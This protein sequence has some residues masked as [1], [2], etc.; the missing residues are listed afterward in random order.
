MKGIGFFDI[1]RSEG[2]FK[3]KAV[4]LV[5]HVAGWLIA[6][7]LPCR[8]R[9]VGSLTQGAVRFLIIRPGGMGDAVFLLPIIR[10]LKRMGHS[11]DVLCE[12]RNAQ[13]FTSQ[14]ELCGRVFCYDV[15]AEFRDV[16]RHE[17]DVVVDTE[18]WHHLSAI[19]AYFIRSSLTVGFDTRFSRAKLFDV[20]VTHDLAEYEL[21]CFTR[22][23]EAFGISSVP[24]LKGSYQAPI[25][26]ISWAKEAVK[27]AYVAFALGGSISLR[28][29]TLAQ[30][31]SICRQALSKG[32]GVV[33]VGGDDV[34]SYAHEVVGSIKD[35]RVINFVGQ[36]TLAKSA[37][38][39]A[40]AKRFIGHDSGLLHIAGA[41]GIPSIAIFGPGN[42][43]K[44]SPKGVQ[45]VV[46]H[47]GLP[48]SPCTRFGYTVVTCSGAYV[49]M[50]DILKGVNEKDL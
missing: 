2:T 6:C 44:W 5:D 45:D 8:R 50:Q 16:F 1:F 20:K 27:G 36:T 13:I 41:L 32:Y 18:Q 40:G 47:T 23:F 17:Y 31:Q 24:Q 29:F 30:V 33:L 19:V 12:R 10:E 35:E 21:K 14:Q 26:D 25:A 43:E 11:V 22:L 4:K 38:L 28:R 37:A 34:A 7:C 39:I 15:L 48:C 3:L 42:K 9:G 46:I 49:C